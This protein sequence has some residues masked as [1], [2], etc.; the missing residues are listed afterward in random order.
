MLRRAYEHWTRMI[1]AIRMAAQRTTTKTHETRWVARGK[2]I[3]IDNERWRGLINNNNRRWCLGNVNLANTVKFLIE[4]SRRRV[5]IARLRNGKCDSPSVWL[6]LIKSAFFVFWHLIL[7]SNVFESIK[8]ICFVCNANFLYF[9]YMRKFRVDLKI[10]V[11]HH[12]FM[13]NLNGV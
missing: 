12:Y 1:H 7:N 13:L 3:H 5:V 10:N 4:L 8:L 9:L 6:V 2:I 11:H